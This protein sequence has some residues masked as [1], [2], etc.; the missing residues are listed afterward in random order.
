[1]NKHATYQQLRSQLA[2]LKLV[3]AAEQLP[4]ALEA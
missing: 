2:H 4:A 1:M 3:A